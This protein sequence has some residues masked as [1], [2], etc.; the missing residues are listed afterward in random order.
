MVTPTSWLSVVFAILLLCCCVPTMEVDAQET[1]DD[2][3]DSPPQT[4]PLTTRIEALAANRAAITAARQELADISQRAENVASDAERETFSRTIDDLQGEVSELEQRRERLFFGFAPDETTAT[5]DDSGESPDL[6]ALLIQG[7]TPV[8]DWIE[9][10]TADTRRI[11]QLEGEIRRQ[12]HQ[13]ETLERELQG[14]L[15]LDIV[16]DRLADPDAEELTT[17]RDS[18]EKRLASARSQ[19]EALQVE[20]AQERTRQ[21]RR[22]LAADEDGIA[23]LLIDQGITLFMGLG[24]GLLAYGAATLLHWVPR[25]LFRRFLGR[26]PVPLRAYWLIMRLVSLFLAYVAAIA[27]FNARR[28]WVL[29]L[30]GLAVVVGTLY[31]LGRALPRMMEQISLLLNLGAVQERERLIFDGIPFEVT[32]LSFYTTLAN[33]TLQ[34]AELQ[35]PVRGLIGLHSRPVAPGEPWFPTAPG[36]WVLLPGDDKIAQVERQTPELVQLRLLG[37]LTYTLRTT[38][39]LDRGPRNLSQGFRIETLFTL[40]YRHRPEAWDPIPALMKHALWEGIVHLVSHTQVRSLEVELWR[41][42]P[43]GLEYEIEMD[44]SGEAAP[45]YEDVER[46]LQRLLI[47]ASERHHWTIALPQI[48]LHNPSSPVGG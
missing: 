3:R 28:D 27:V 48:T 18:T 38:A 13:V 15:E 40:D 45:L 5:A 21:R 7:L 4:D 30:V 9:Q 34:G 37:G 33:P 46:T 41:A 16:A 22:F 35:L 26:W 17:K 20:L 47:E 8:I 36:D 19:V 2:G 24:V 31:T 25:W 43:S 14:L 23:A 29:T 11:D 10:L 32:Q 1:G 39:F 12:R 42:G 6:E 44:L